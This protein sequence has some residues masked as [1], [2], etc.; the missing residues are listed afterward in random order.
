MAR[1][2]FPIQILLIFGG[3]RSDR[4]W[5]IRLK[6][7]RLPNFNTLFQFR[8]TKFFKSELLV[9][10]TESCSRDKHMQKAY[11]ILFFL[12]IY[13]YFTLFSLFLHIC[14]CFIFIALVSLLRSTKEN[15]IYSS[16]RGYQFCLRAWKGTLYQTL[17]IPLVGHIFMPFSSPFWISRYDVMRTHEF[18]AT[19]SI[20]SPKQSVTGIT[21]A[22]LDYVAQSFWC[23][24]MILYI[25][26]DDKLSSC[27]LWMVQIST[28]VNF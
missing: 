25:S 10:F 3:R 27:G 18:T 26:Q 11:F 19:R 16:R 6:I 5:D 14:F 13:V 9:C 4:Y 21:A 15:A 7:H 24:V 2:V 22:S 8:L 28:L 23:Q 1:V 20:A 17:D 12:R